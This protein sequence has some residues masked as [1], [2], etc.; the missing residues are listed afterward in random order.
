MGKHKARP[1]RGRVIP[2]LGASCGLLAAAGLTG[3]LRPVVVLPTA[4][5]AD[6][7]A[8]HESS[9]S[10]I[11]AT[12]LLGGPLEMPAIG[13]VAP[14]FDER[15]A[16]LA[17]AAHFS[18]VRTTGTPVQNTMGPVAPATRTFV[19][20]TPA[21][22]RLPD[23]PAPPAPPTTPPTTPP[24]HVTPPPTQPPPTQPPPT[25]PPP[26]QPPPTQPP[27]T[28]PPPPPP[29]PTEP[30]PP[31][32]EPP[33]VPED[34]KLGL[35]QSF[36]VL[37]ETTGAIAFT[38]MVDAITPDVVCTAD[39]SSAAENG[40]LVGVHLHVTT[41]DAQPAIDPSDF[42]FFGSDV[43]P[44]TASAGACM[45]EADSFPSGPLGSGQ[46][47]VGTIVLDVPDMAG[48]IA[49][50]PDAWFTSLLWGF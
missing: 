37:D 49:Y 42:E 36:D 30:P 47:V 20:T 4:G 27:P 45:A 6:L 26:T 35:A 11:D 7:A 34:V 12:T 29:P 13:V 40:H 48:T 14:G 43:D 15:Y 9:G 46:A 25:Q 44:D 16:A 22:T 50:R 28:E 18:A 19:P 24:P 41:R 33:A 31:V 21:E 23:P 3:G 38:I 17:A 39:G 1:G 2:L 8:V 10:A 32:E 5:D